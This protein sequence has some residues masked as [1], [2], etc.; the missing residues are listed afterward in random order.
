MIVAIFC[1]GVKQIKAAEPA[2]ADYTHYPIFQV[3]AVEPNILIILDNSGSMNYN[4]YGSYPGNGGIVTD[5]PYVGE[6]F[7]ADLTSVVSQ[8]SDDAEDPAVGTV[9]DHPDLDLGSIEVVG[10]RFQNLDIPRGATI[11]KAHITFEALIGNGNNSD[12]TSLTFHGEA[13]DN[14]ATFNI[15]S[16]SDI[17]D[18]DDTTASVA[19]DN[20]P[21]WTDYQTYDSPDVSS[22]IQE[23]I[24]RDGWAGGNAIAFKVTGSGIREARAYDHGPSLYVEYEPPEWTKYYG[25]FNPDYFYYESSNKFYHKYKK[26]AYV[27]D[28]A[29]SGYWNVVDLNGNSH[30]LYD[31]EVVSASLWDGN[32]LNWLCMRRIDVMRK[33]L[34]GGLATSRTGGGNQTNYGETPS[35]SDR[36]FIKRYD[37]TNKAAVSPYD[38]DYHY[39]MSS[40]YIYVDSDNDPFS[41]ALANFTIAIQKDVNY[42]PA[43]FHNYDSGDNLAGVLQKV[44]SKARWG[45]EWFNDGTGNGESGGFIASTIGTNMVSLVTDLQNTGCDTWTPLG[46]AYYVATQYFKQEDVASG[47]DYPNNVI[48]NAND[49]QDPYY[50]GTEFVECADSFVI[51]LTDGA[52]TMDGNIPAFLK[53]Y[54][55]DG[56]NTACDE[57]T[58]TDCDYPYGGTDFLD[59]IALYARTNDLRNDLD[60][61]QNLILYTIYAFGSD[62]NAE[63]L[64]RDAAK[65][66][67][68]EDKN[69]NNV[70]DLQDEW[71]EDGDGNPD[72]Y[73]KADNG[74]ELERKLIQAIN[75]ILSRA[76]AGTAVSV[77]ATTGEGEGNL[78]QAYFRPVVPEGLTE[79]NWVGYLQS[80]WVDPQG[81]LREDTVQ[82][83][84]LNVDEDRVITYFLD[85]D[86]GDTRIKRFAVSGTTPYPDVDSAPYVVLQLHEI[87]PVWEA[88]SRLAQRNPD[89]RRIFT[90]L[91]K[92][93]DGVV[94][95]GSDH[96]DDSGEVVRFHI[97]SADSIKPYLGLLDD[98]TW[99][100]IG[101]THDER[102]RDVINYIRGTEVTGLRTR[103][104]NGRVWKLGDIVYSTPVSVS[105]PVENFHIIYSDE[106]YQTFYNDFKDRET[107]VYVGGNDGMLHAFT[108]W[109]YNTATGAFT[110][111]PSTT[112]EI[113]DELW[114]YIPQSLL[115]HLKWLPS[116]DYTHV[117]YVDLKPKVF[118]AKILPDDTYYSD[119]DSDDDWGTFLLAGL[120][121]GGKHIWAE[122]YFDDG[123]G[124]TVY[125]TRHFY[126]SYVCMD[127]TEP[128]EPKV[129]WERTYSDLEMTTSFPAV[130]KVKNKWFAVFG[131]GSTDYD[132]SSTKNGHIFVVDLKTGE[133]Y[134]NGT[135]DWLFETNEAKAFMNSPVSLDKNLDFSVNEIYFGET[136]LSGSWKGKVY[137]VSVPWVDASGDYDGIDINNYVDNPNDADD[138]WILSELFNATKPIT[139]P[140]ALSVDTFDNTWIYGGT[141]RYISIAD[142]ST[143]DTQYHFGLKDPF[144][145]KD[146]I[147]DGYY[148]DYS[149]FLEL[150]IA[151][152]FDGDSYVVIKGGADVYDGGVRMGAYQALVNEARQYDG[153]IRSL[154]T[155]G[156]RILTKAAILGGVVFTPS[157][158]PN[159]DI[160]GFG[161]ESNLYGR[162]YESGTAYYKPVFR[163][164]VADVTIDGEPRKMVLDKLNLG[165]GKA[166]AVG[167]H[168]GSEGARAFI[169]QSTGTVLAQDLDPAFNIKSGLRSWEEK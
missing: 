71:D 7:R 10:M 84:A 168:V 27:G 146:H 49:G 148:H 155:S 153:W 72:T 157:F 42:E 8:A 118:D 86:S 139:A 23:I 92:D 67:G 25:Y 3:N 44:G 154:T 55:G 73:Y 149:S 89:T 165:Y 24:D 158:V 87:S 61:D 32:W 133:P 79:V 64:L 120:N 48:P 43:D 162:Y 20:I 88:G 63:S 21:A 41:G 122:G 98:A 40:G 163:N 137:K 66:G 129:L 160:C 95:E 94:D 169:Q 11:T 114:A 123:S 46:E 117:D 131:S 136:Y 9:Y 128:R 18:R 54:D 59:D 145:N 101:T 124:V 1:L 125:E 60:G 138:P 143:T 111:P 29:S 15:G 167:V 2:M 58:D 121:M 53:D 26:I 105:K 116:P 83:H 151:D 82:D 69:G 37:T 4:A 81:N 39:G 166:S 100:Y 30:Q 65:N 28:P 126:P 141:G 102:V 90:Y 12:P 56:D 45:N 159:G 109:Q 57:S 156:E 140:L 93:K 108:S 115:P 130:V 97:N 31:T 6:P 164:G 103:T 85:S 110:K 47:L 80:L 52:S 77:L 104:L 34:M 74:Y 99:G 14:A 107:V 147:A 68:F 38:G 132:G 78:V 142:K 119:A 17:Y 62:A 51:L 19:W 134:K 127:V 75:D 13:S 22:I 33:V 70:P 50:N 161:G 16:E 91:D 113:G 144:Y 36:T 152:L 150:E 135:N 106:S 35:Q 96:F 112:E 76:A 5:A